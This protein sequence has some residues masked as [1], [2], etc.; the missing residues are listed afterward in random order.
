GIGV[1]RFEDLVTGFPSLRVVVDLKA[2]GMAKALG[3][4]IDLHGLHDRVIVGSY[5]DRWIDELRRVTGGGVATST[6][7]ALTRMWL[8]ASRLGRAAAGNASALQVPTQIRG[9]RVVDERLVRA[10]HRWGL[11]VHAWTVNQPSEMTRLLD[12]GVDG[13]VTDRPDLLRQVLI[14]RAEWPA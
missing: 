7:S 9:M 10:A 12:M 6:G 11:Q 14:E 13:L 3:E 4:L 8:V 2:D 1:P 5:H